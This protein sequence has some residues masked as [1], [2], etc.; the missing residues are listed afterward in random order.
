MQV[1]RKTY[2]MVG[3]CISGSPGVDVVS[4]IDKRPFHSVGQQS[5][6]SGTI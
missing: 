5:H 1:K 3:V 6:I 2:T 4:S